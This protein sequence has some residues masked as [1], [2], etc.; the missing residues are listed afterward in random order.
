LG[1]YALR[2]IRL[3][4]PTEGTLRERLGYF[5]DEEARAIEEIVSDAPEQWWT[6][7]FPIW[8]AGFAR[9]AASGG[10]A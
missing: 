6:I 10:P 2:G 8:P 5:M 3:H 1:Q 4:T 7:F 9:A